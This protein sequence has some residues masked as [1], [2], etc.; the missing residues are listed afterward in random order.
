MNSSTYKTTSGLSPACNQCTSYPALTLFTTSRL[1]PALRPF[2]A[3]LL[4]VSP[5]SRFPYRV[6]C[7]S[8][9]LIVLLRTTGNNRMPPDRLHGP[10]DA[11]TPRLYLPS[12]AYSSSGSRMPKYPVASGMRCCAI[13]GSIVGHPFFLLLFPPSARSSPIPGTF[14]LSSSFR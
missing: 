10:V 2:C 8:G 12:R 1:S 3:P 13:R 5:S 11:P 14:P 9:S 7:L 6:I 4:Y